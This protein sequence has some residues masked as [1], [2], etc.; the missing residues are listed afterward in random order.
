MARAIWRHSFERD[1]DFVVFRRP[2]TIC[3]TTFNAGAP[4]DKTLVPTRKLRQLFEAH[5][6][7]LAGVDKPGALPENPG[8]QN[9]EMLIGSS[10][11]ASTYEIAGETV[12]LGAIVAAAHELSGMTVEEWNELP[13]DDREALLRAEL[14]RLLATVPSDA[15]AD[16][17]DTTPSSNAEPKS[18]PLDHDGNGKKGGAVA[19]DIAKLRADYTALLGKK[20]FNGW[21]ADELQR[22][23][24]E[25]L[26][27]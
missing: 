8:E 3:G 11:L 15:G 1:K 13:N 12:Q 27:N 4:F 17:A 22:R 20:P 26:A 16:P 2:L 24:D 7:M 5:R 6:I 18:D 23:I 21:K 9:D 10:V 25:A 14:D 19:P